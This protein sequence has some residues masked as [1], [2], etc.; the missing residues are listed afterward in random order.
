MKIGEDSKWQIQAE[1]QIPLKKFKK[2][3][4][5]LDDVKMSSLKN[6]AKS[7]NNKELMRDA[8]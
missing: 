3:F 1:S 4:R 8:M 5:I 6:L 2:I 7:V